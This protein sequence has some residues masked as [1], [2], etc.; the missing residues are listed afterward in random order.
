MATYTI[1]GADG[2]KYGPVPEAEVKAWI[3]EGRL[4]AQS[5]AKAESDA[6]FRP[7]ATFPEFAE[8]L[9]LTP[10]PFIPPPM[11]GRAGQ[12]DARERA[13]QEVKGPAICLKVVAVLSFLLSLWGL[14]KVLF[15]R[16]GIDEEISRLLTQY[17]E[18]QDAQFQKTLRMIF[19]PI[20]IGSNLFAMLISALIFWGATRMQQLK[21]YE[22]CFVAA[23]LAMLPCATNC[24]AW[25]FGLPFGIWALVVL[26]KSGVKS[27]FR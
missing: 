3:A 12:S 17:P 4:N 24:C 26:N 19:G 9:G 15:F 2:K 18:L 11:P 7:L 20:G 22:L 27:Q 1:I 25:V 14:I 10:P 5:H 6:D 21:N 16:N 13:L 8:A 23:I